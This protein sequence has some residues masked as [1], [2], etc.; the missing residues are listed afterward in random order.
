VKAN[1]AP[2]PLDLRASRASGSV[3]EAWVSFE[4]LSLWKLRSPLRP[5]AGGSSL[6]SL[7]RKLFIPAHAWINVPSTEKCS[8]DTSALTRGRFSTASMNAAAIS[9]SS[10]RSRFLVNTVGTQTGSSTD[11][12]T[13]QRNSRL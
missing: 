11:S 5:G 13:N 6:P 8:S 9:P 3:V 2:S 7:R 4:R 12:P 1:L 10:S